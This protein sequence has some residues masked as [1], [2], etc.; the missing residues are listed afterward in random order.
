MLD[1]LEK[2]KEELEK[3]KKKKAEWEAKVKRLE[4]K[5][6]D[7]EKMAVHEMVKAANL[8]PEELARLIAHSREHLPGEVPMEDIVNTDNRLEDTEDEE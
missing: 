3:A 1:R 7:E 8:S 2:C 6:Q 4:K 5:V